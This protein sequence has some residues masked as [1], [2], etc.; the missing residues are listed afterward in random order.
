MSTQK[1]SFQ[2]ERA[3]SYVRTAAESLLEKGRIM[4][5]GLPETMQKSGQA[6]NASIKDVFSE[7]DFHFAL[8]VE[9][10]LSRPG[11][12]FLGVSALCSLMCVSASSYYYN[13]DNSGILKYLT[14]GMTIDELTNTLYDLMKTVYRH[15]ME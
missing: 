9:K 1:I 2:D 14:T 7:C 6:V 8:Y 12:L 15:V 10:D 11:R 13:S 3:L 5:E 4:I